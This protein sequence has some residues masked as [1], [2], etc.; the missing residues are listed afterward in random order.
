MGFLRNFEIPKPARLKLKYKPMRPQVPTIC[1][2]LAHWLQIGDVDDLHAH[3]L[4]DEPCEDLRIRRA[5]AEPP[6]ELDERHTPTLEDSPDLWRR[7][8]HDR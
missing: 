5:A 1:P 2:R 4:L 6:G 8:G 3:A 7:F